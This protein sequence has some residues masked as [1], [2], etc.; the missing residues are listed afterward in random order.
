MELLVKRFTLVYQNL[1]E[2]MNLVQM[3]LTGPLKAHV[4]DLNAPMNVKPNM[5]NFA[6]KC[7]FLGKIEKV[8]GGHL[9][10]VPKTFENTGIINVAKGIEIDGPER[11]RTALHHEGLEPKYVMRQGCQISLGYYTNTKGKPKV[12]FP[13]KVASKEENHLMLETKKV[14]L[15]HQGK[16]CLCCGQNV[17]KWLCATKANYDCA[18]DGMLEG[19]FGLQRQIMF[20]PRMVCK[21]MVLRYLG[22]S[23][24]GRGPNVRKLSWGA[25]TNHV[26]W[27][28]HSLVYFAYTCDNDLLK[29]GLFTYEKR[30]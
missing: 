28:G 10:E 3:R 2:V 16:S 11:S 29:W 25:K 18:A 17:R 1:C 21:I 22:K 6:K 20:V 5:N 15:F 23:R 30:L 26:A 9:V 12:K 7:I 24:F 8:G 27:G 14:A 4:L 19:G 13:T